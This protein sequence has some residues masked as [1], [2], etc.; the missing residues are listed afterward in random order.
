M[1]RA[2][3]LRAPEHWP[4][5]SL[6]PQDRP[7]WIVFCAICSNGQKFSPDTSRVPFELRATK[8][9]NAS[10]DCRAAI[11]LPAQSQSSPP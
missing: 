2:E 6:M 10:A 9:L 4:R 3:A 11:C 8:P 1:L 7:I 5:S